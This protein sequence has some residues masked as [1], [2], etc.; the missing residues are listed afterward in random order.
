MRNIWQ[1]STLQWYYSGKG[2]E[3]MYYA[4]RRGKRKQKDKITLAYEVF[5]VLL[6]LA[7]L[8]YAVVTGDVPDP[9][10]YN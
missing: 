3:R 7:A 5:A 10:N 2:G 4:R 1:L 9:D 8:I 6:V